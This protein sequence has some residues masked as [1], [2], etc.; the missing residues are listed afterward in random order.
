MD[1]VLV[2]VLLVG[3]C[4]LAWCAAGALRRHRLEGELRTARADLDAL[5]QRV[6][7]LDRTRP[8]EHL[9]GDGADAPEYLITSLADA[10]GDP[11]PAEDLEHRLT[12]REFVDV[13]LGESLV[14]VAAFA[15][16]VRRAASPENRH[17]IRFEMAREVKRA[18][19]Q[20]RRDL[21]DARR[22]LRTQQ[23]HRAGGAGAAGA[24]AAAAA[25]GQD[26]A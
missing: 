16:G 6:D 18:R 15:Y 12:G 19:R 4:L 5:R 24:G 14:K 17:R 20:R 11:V 25:A 9:A 3:A 21:K 22:H 8:V 10:Q 7:R 23:V 13:A 1:P 26:A 2:L